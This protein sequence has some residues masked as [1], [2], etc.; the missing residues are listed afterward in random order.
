LLHSGRLHWQ[1]QCF[2]IIGFSSANCTQAYK[3]RSVKIFIELTLEEQKELA[4]TFIE[5]SRANPA[6]T[7]TTVTY[8]VTK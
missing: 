2:E 5:L 1:W 3:Y 7:I 4:A 8:R 6:E